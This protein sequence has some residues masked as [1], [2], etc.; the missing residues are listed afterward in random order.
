MTEMLMSVLIN[1]V[2]PCVFSNKSEDGC[3]KYGPLA[4]SLT[5]TFTGFYVGDFFPCL[6]WVDV[7]TGQIPRMKQLFAEF[8]EFL[9]G[10]ARE[11][12]AGAD[13][14]D[15]FYVIM[16]L[17][18]D[19]TYEMD[20]TPDN[21]KA[22][23]LDIFVGGND[24][25]ATTTKWVMAEL[26]NNA[27]SMKKVQEEVRNVVG[28]KPKIDMEDINKME[29]LKC[30]IKEALR[31]HQPDVFV[32]RRTSA[33]VK[34]GGY[35]VPSDTTIWI[36]AWA[37]NRDPKWWE[38][39]DEFIPER[40]Q[41]NSIDFQG[42]DFHYI[43]FGFGRW[44]CPGMSFAVTLV[45][46]VIANLLYWFDWKLPASEH[47]DMTELYGITVAKKIPLHVLP[48]SRSSY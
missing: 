22:T 26:L 10:V 42:Q 3:S 14:K 28:D 5:T 43:P 9:N 35:D 38:K 1:I 33:S 7:V 45:E 8:D 46:Y 18:K 32:I 21:V 19:G 30:V 13:E 39:P 29:Y 24:T 34:L 47:L 11:H 6:R 27:S 20:L 36:N 41:K 48:I 40:F 2:S 17:R 15:L 12:G 31:L 44:G 23:L 4:K 25:S 16:Q 37:I